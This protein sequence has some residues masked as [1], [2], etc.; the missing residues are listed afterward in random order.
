MCRLAYLLLLP[1]LSLEL[2]L[3]LL[4]LLAQLFVLPL[5]LRSPARLRLL[6]LLLFLRL[7]PALLLFL[8][9]ET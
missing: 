4:R 1:R 7:T 8:V 6:A 3:V 2:S 5:T 9:L